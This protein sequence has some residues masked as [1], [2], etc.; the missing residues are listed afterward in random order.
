MRFGKKEKYEPRKKILKVLSQNDYSNKISFLN[1][2]SIL[3]VNK[4]NYSGYNK[5]FFKMKENHNY[6]NTNYKLNDIT[7]KKTREY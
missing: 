7:K 5:A 6:K 2:E 4:S 3:S 1:S